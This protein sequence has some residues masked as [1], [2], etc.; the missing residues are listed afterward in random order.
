MRCHL[1]LTGGFR[2]PE[3][4]HQLGAQLWLP[5][6]L[7]SLDLRWLQGIAAGF[8]FMGT[9]CAAGAAVLASLAA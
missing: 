1:A 6:V 8:S 5:G 3:G 9:R 2:E 7:L 4:F